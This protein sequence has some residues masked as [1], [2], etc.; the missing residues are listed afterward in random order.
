[1]QVTAIHTFCVAKL[2]PDD[3]QRLHGS[4]YTFRVT[5]LLRVLLLLLKEESIVTPTVL[6]Q[7]QSGE[8]PVERDLDLQRKRVGGFSIKDQSGFATLSV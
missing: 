8:Q 4:M 1:M 3:R 2:R 5:I 7:Q 6:A